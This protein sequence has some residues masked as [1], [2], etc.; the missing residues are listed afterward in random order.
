MTGFLM[1]K[2]TSGHKETD[3]EG[4]GHVTTEAGIW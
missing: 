3:M 2:E 1:R 4:R